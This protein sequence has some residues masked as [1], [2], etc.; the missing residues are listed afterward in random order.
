MKQKDAKEEIREKIIKA[1][2]VYE[3]YLLGKTFLYVYGESFFEVEFRS[4]RFLHLTGVDSKLT[5]E[6]FF[7]DT[8]RNRLKRGQFYLNKNKGNSF[9]NAKKKLNCLA[10]LPKITNSL[11]CVL[12]RMHTMTMEYTLGLTNLNFTLG[13]VEDMD[14]Q[15]NKKSEIFLPR[16]IRI[17]D[18]SIENSENSDFIDFIFVKES[19]ERKYK[20]ITFQDKSRLIPSS[21]HDKISKSLLEKNLKA[22]KNNF[23]VK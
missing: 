18:K 8:R 12:E 22:C 5:A 1:A 2:K 14:A 16:T 20:K 23:P 6:S 13:L 21:V 11:V 15:K 3:R 9:K 19:S 17:K 7:K 4:N 10:V